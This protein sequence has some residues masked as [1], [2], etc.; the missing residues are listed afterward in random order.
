M[1][2]LLVAVLWCV[3]VAIPAM[4]QQ[5]PPPKSAGEVSGPASGNIMTKAYA[6]MVG[7]MAYLWGYAMV[8][9][10]NRRNAF[11]VVTAQHGNVPGF[12]GGVV[13]MAPVGQIAMLT[14]Y[15]S[16]QQTFV[17][18]PNQDVVYG[19]GFFALDKDPVVFQVPDFG[20]RFWIYA[21][22][23]ARTDQ[24]AQIGKPYGTKPGFYLL[25]GPNWKGATPAGITAVIRCPTELGFAIPRIFKDDTAQDTKAVQPLLSRIVF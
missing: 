11:S 2:K 25:V 21:V 23:N 16:P 13:P 5:V 18:C 10:Y 14:D 3:M 4:A 24:I 22:Y 19:V 17:A 8:D 12:N 6:Q 9:M 20:D 7:R 15:L 1:K